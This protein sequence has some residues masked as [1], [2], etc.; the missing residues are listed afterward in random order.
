M[1]KFINILISIFILLFF[2]PSC[3]KCEPLPVHVDPC[4]GLSF[5]FAVDVQPIINTKCAT[6]PGC[7]A[8]G[9]INRGGPLTNYNEVFDKKEACKVSIIT[10]TMPPN[11]RDSLTTVQK[12]IIICWINSGAPNN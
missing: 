7:H 2:I 5:K 4:A 9:S 6:R 3:Q 11:P 1:K 8:A 12:N 10:S